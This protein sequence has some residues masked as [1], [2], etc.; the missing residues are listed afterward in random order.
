MIFVFRS[1]ARQ[2]KK[3]ARYSGNVVL[4]TE[5]MAMVGISPLPA[6]LEAEKAMLFDSLA[7]KEKQHSQLKIQIGFEER[8]MA[9]LA[10]GI[11][12]K[13]F[14]EA[15]LDSTVGKR[16]LAAMWEK[17]HAKR[18]ALLAGTPLFGAT[19]HD[20]QGMTAIDGAYTVL[21]MVTGDRCIMAVSLPSG[22]MFSILLVDEPA[23]WAGP[24]FT[25]YRHG[26]IHVIAP[27]IDTFIGPMWLP[28]F[29]AHKTGDIENTEL[30][31][32]EKRRAAGGIQTRSAA[33]TQITVLAH[34][35]FAL[36]KHLQTG[37]VDHQMQRCAATQG[38]Q[39]D[40]EIPGAATQRRV[41]G[42][43]QIGEGELVHARPAKPCSARSGRRNTC[44][45]PSSIWITLPSG[46]ATRSNFPHSLSRDSATEIRSAD[47][48]GDH[49]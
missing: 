23:L 5:E 32:L 49:L 33:T 47:N 6:E 29:L 17:D 12:Y 36:A 20:L 21:I 25:D 48:P 37:A 19:A 2:F 7:K 46:P 31:K 45:S 4:L 27:Q 16:N 22:R 30:A 41:V 13:L 44:L 40:V 15:G 26:V 35:P 24:E 34:L 10:R 42:H 43:W 1:Y 39:H 18:A 11:G 8:F 3:A 14:G 28:D 38:R 9:K